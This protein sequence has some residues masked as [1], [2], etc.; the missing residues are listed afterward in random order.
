MISR[1]HYLAGTWALFAGAVVGTVVWPFPEV[2]AVALPTD[3]EFRYR[4]RRVRV[5][6]HGREVRIRVNGTKDV[7]AH[8]GGP[9]GGY[10][11]HSLPFTEFDSPQLLAQGVIDA[12]DAGLL[13]I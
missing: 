11:T 9:R 5:T 2:D 1:R 6:P 12:E 8:R 7:H 3:D 4:G 10:L 13:L